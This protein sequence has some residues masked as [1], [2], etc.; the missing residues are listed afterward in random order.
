MNNYFTYLLL[1][2]DNSYYTGITNDLERRLSEHQ[3][4][5]H[6]ESYTFSRRPVKL[7]WFIECNNVEL[8]IS[9]EKQI[10]GW[11]RKKKNALINNDWE[12][13]ISISNEKNLKKKKKKN[14]K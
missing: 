9:Y 1:C 14:N 7:V 10:K 2:A 4:W 13:I 11:S 6:P 3:N 5:L 8:A 12:T